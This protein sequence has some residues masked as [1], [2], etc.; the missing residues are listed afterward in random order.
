MAGAA[1]FP[2]ANNVA[3]IGLADKPGNPGKT[4]DR[5]TIQPSTSLT[6]PICCFILVKCNVMSCSPACLRAV[7]MTH[8]RNCATCKTPRRRSIGQ[9]LLEVPAASD[10]DFEAAFASIL[11]HRAR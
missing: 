10:H 7:A 4:N 6:R 2:F 1:Q 11:Q 9:Q 3:S 8:G 5:T